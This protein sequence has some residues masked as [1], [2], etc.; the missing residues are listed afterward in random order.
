M[1]TADMWTLDRLPCPLL[2][3]NINDFD[4]LL[5]LPLAPP[6]RQK[7]HLCTRHF[8]VFNRGC[9]ELIPASR[10]MKPTDFNHLMTCPLAPSSGD[11]YILAPLDQH[12]WMLVWDEH[13]SL[14]RLCCSALLTDLTAWICPRK[15]ERGAGSES[16]RRFPGNSLTP[17]GLTQQCCWVSSFNSS[18]QTVCMTQFMSFPPQHSLWQRTEPMKRHTAGAPTC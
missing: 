10:R 18:S 17:P 11:P 14:Q 16:A 15:P 7:L 13:F 9:C 1:S 8:R 12:V 2:S 4:D 3:M 5:I 6:S